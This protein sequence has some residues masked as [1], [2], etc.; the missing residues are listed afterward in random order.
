MWKGPVVLG[1]WRPILLSPTPRKPQ[2]VGRFFGLGLVELHGLDAL[3]ASLDK[4]DRRLDRCE[5]ALRLV[6]RELADA[7]DEKPH[8]AEKPTDIDLDGVRAAQ[9]SLGDV[10]R[11]RQGRGRNDEYLRA[12][13]LLRDV[14]ETVD[15]DG[16]PKSSRHE[17]RN[18]NRE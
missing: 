13:G 15:E 16:N 18:C 3:G 11:H 9:R 4:G 14:V 6:R 2:Q 7:L 5:V 1:G 12:Q 17:R 10:D 8:A